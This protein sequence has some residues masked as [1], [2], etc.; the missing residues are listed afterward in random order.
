MQ[1]ISR[2]YIEKIGYKK[3]IVE[4]HMKNNFGP[5]FKVYFRNDD[6]ADEYIEN[7]RDKSL[8]RVTCT[9]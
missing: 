3:P 4:L 8:Y 1:L 5:N 9:K 7:K 6:H 2:K